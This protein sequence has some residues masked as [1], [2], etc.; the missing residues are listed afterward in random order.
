MHML[1]VL[2]QAFQ[3]NVVSYVVVILQLFHFSFFPFFIFSQPDAIQQL[4]KRIEIL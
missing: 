1:C 2:R 3:P 4:L